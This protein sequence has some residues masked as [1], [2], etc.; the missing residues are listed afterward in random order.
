MVKTHR[1][2][3][4]NALNVTAIQSRHCTSLELIEDYAAQ[5]AAGVQFDPCCAIETP[6]GQIFIWDGK[7]RLEAAIKNGSM[8]LV[9]IEPGMKNEAHW[10]ACSA[11]KKH[12]LR[13]SQADMQKAVQDALTLRPDKSDHEIGLWVGCDHKTVGKYRELLQASGELLRTPTRTVT[14][15]EQTYQMAMPIK[16]APVETPDLNQPV[17]HLTG[18]VPADVQVSPQK[19]LAFTPRHEQED[20]ATNTPAKPTPTQK[21]LI[22]VIKAF[23]SLR[24]EPFTQA[25]EELGH[26][27]NCWQSKE[28]YVSLVNELKA[29]LESLYVIDNFH[30]TVRDACQKALDEWTALYQSGYRGVLESDAPASDADVCPE[31]FASEG[32]HEIFCSKFAAEE[33]EE[34][35]EAEKEELSFEARLER[36]H[37]CL[38]RYFLVKIDGVL[39]VTKIYEVNEH[40]AKVRGVTYP[41]DPHVPFKGMAAGTLNFELADLQREL[42]QKNW[43]RSKWETEHKKNSNNAEPEPEQP[44]GKPAEYPSEQPEP[45]NATARQ[46]LDTLELNQSW[47]NPIVKRFAD[48]KYFPYDTT[49]MKLFRE[50]TIRKPTG[51]TTRFGDERLKRYRLDGVAVIKIN[52]H[53]YKP[54]LVGFEVKVDKH[55]LLNDKKM[56]EYLDYVDMFFL[57]IPRTLGVASIDFG[58]NHP[59]KEQIGEM[60]VEAGSVEIHDIPEMLQPGERE[61]QE[62]VTE[63]LMKALWKEEKQVHTQR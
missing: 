47:V 13:R 8:L 49:D 36:C 5:M 63:L 48:S 27:Y 33:D 6:E 16:T 39:G 26:L 54:I 42:T 20:T 1:L 14:R 21:T 28:P 45:M 51:E 53:R 32:E 52:D 24:F 4:P 55:D 44:A 7:H 46:I 56:H 34:R 41:Y 18:F 43:E 58:E 57:V 29:H 2:I 50:V 17:R 11:N 30:F 62:I 35:R 31:C 25:R 40:L 3:N 12:G 37:I 23:M 10:R 61:R 59:Y 9:E 38:G 15:G 60:I 19:S 22:G